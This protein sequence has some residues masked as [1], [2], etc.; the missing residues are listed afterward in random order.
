MWRRI[1]QAH[2]C[3][4]CCFLLACFRHL[5]PAFHAS[6][7]TDWRTDSL[8]KMVLFP[9]EF[10]LSLTRARS[11]LSVCLCLSSLCSCVRL[12]FLWLRCRNYGKGP[13]RD[14]DPTRRR[15]NFTSSRRREQNQQLP[16]ERASED[17]SPSYLLKLMTTT[18]SWLLSLCV[19]IFLPRNLIEW[20][21][22]GASQPASQLGGG[23]AE[24]E[25]TDEALLHLENNLRRDGRPR[26]CLTVTLKLHSQL[27]VNPCHFPPHQEVQNCCCC[28]CCWEMER[29]RSKAEQNPRLYR[30]TEEDEALRF[31]A[32][33][34]L[35][36]KVVLLHVLLNDDDDEEE[37]EEEGQRV[38][39]V[40]PGM[41]LTRCKC[42][43]CKSCRNAGN[44]YPPKNQ[45]NCSFSSYY[46]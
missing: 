46:C 29:S 40:L 44:S 38:N 25:G 26:E 10:S 6:T 30:Q 16:S 11:L 35:S 5:Q 15:K 33:K 7:H 43:C 13:I 3:C 27:I 17:E 39:I 9:L 18:T 32:W 22:D 1:R 4:C 2:F 14:P 20:T 23:R 36:I 34:R 24:E 19:C 8:A 45:R 41:Q 12:L 28:C 37:E 42:G 31:F 21:G